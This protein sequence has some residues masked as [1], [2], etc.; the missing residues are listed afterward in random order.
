MPARAG[1]VWCPWLLSLLLYSCSLPVP[2]SS[3]S[4]A[5][6]LRVCLLLL[7]P[8]G[9]VPPPPA[10]QG[11]EERSLLGK[12]GRRVL[13]LALLDTAMCSLYKHILSLDATHTPTHTHTCR[14]AP[15]RSA[16]DDDERDVIVK[17]DRRVN[18]M[19]KKPLRLGLLVEPTVR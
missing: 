3:P 13:P 7:Q 10:H 15:I 17:A 4:S 5:A 8:R 1:A 18:E 14:L 12:G 2:S 11:K 9:D 16:L 6:A 19:F